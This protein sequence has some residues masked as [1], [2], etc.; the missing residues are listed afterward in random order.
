MP[1]INYE[2]NLGFTWGVPAESTDEA[3]L[4][5]LRDLHET[6]GRHLKEGMA[7]TKDFE[8]FSYEIWEDE[9]Q[10]NQIHQ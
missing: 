8:G 2:M 9:Y 5:A 7:N 4:E 6:L 10:P 1:T 3:V